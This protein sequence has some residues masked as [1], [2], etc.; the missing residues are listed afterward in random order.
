MEKGPSPA[1]SRYRSNR[2]KL[3]PAAAVSPIT[4]TV[5]F[6]VTSR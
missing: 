3:Q 2:S 5:M 6:A 1:P 4:T